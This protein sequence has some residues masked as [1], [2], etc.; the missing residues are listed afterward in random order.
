MDVAAQSAAFRTQHEQRR[1][2]LQAQLS[3]VSQQVNLATHEKVQS[4]P[5]GRKL[6][7]KKNQLRTDLETRKKQLYN[8]F[9]SNQQRLN[10][11]YGAECKNPKVPTSSIVSRLP[12]PE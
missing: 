1:Q 4:H 7:D 12:P 3:S 9:V 8:E 5:T 2:E 6:L 11:Q 10:D